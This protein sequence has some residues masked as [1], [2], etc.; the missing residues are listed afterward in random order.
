MKN[1]NAKMDLIYAYRLWLM[2]LVLLTMVSQ[3]NYHNDNIAAIRA[4]GNQCNAEYQII[5][6][7][8]ALNQ[9]EK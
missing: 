1:E 9:G 2:A 6:P 8:E 7:D 5:I 4:V 3:C